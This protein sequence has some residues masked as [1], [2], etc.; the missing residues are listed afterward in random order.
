[1]GKRKRAASFVPDRTEMFA[2]YQPGVDGRSTHCVGFILPRRT[3]F[4]AFNDTKSIGV[5]ST[6]KA[7]ADALTKAVAS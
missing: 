7:A 3:D 6:M 2:V 4:E 5:F 1:M